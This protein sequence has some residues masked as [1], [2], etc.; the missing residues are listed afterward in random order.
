MKT[1][2]STYEFCRE[3]NL[4]PVFTPVSALKGTD[5][6]SRLE[7]QHKLQEDSSHLTNVP[8]PTMKAD[9]VLE[10]LDHFMRKG[11]SMLSILKRTYFYARIIAGNKN[12]SIN[13]II[14]KTIFTFVT[15]RRMKQIVM[16]ENER[17]RKRVES[18]RNKEK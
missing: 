8:H 13:D 3:M 18:N 16:Q 9:E 5:L 17:L 12:N 14:Y 11:Y 6:Y 4:M 7:R 1:Y 15:Q 10:A 2:Y